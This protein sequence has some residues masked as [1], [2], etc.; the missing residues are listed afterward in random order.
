MGSDIDAA[1]EA[2]GRCQIWPPIGW[3]MVQV[4]VSGRASTSS[5]AITSGLITKV[6]GVAS[7]NGSVI[8][9]LG[10]NLDFLSFEAFE[11]S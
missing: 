10:F 8:V 11:V 9:A 5:T 6:L 1:Y 4:S 2:R 7:L 3:C